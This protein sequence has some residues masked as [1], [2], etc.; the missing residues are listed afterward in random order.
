MDKIEDNPAIKEEKKEDGN[1]P[2]TDKELAYLGYL[3]Q[4]L[5]NA[6]L[7]REKPY[8]E[9][10]GMT[11]QSYYDSNIKLANSFMRP[12]LNKEDVRFHTGTTRQ[13]I[14]GLCT[15]VNQLNL[16]SE[17][18]VF[19]KKNIFYSKVARGLETV[20]HQ[21]KKNDKHEEKRS[22]REYELYVQGTAFNEV[23]WTDE[24]QL[25][26]D[27]DL[28]KNWDGKDFTVEW[29]G[30]LKKV[31]SG[32]RVNL[33]QGTRVFLGNIRE[34]FM[35]KQPYAFSYDKVTYEEAKQIYEKWE[36]WK[37]VKKDASRFEHELDQL[38]STY[39]D[40]TLLPVESGMVE[41]VKYQ[42]KWNN[43]FQIILNGVMMMPVGFPMPWKSGKYNITKDV[44]E[45]ITPTFA[46]GAS[47]CKKLKNSQMLENEFWQIA[48]LK[49][50]RSVY[51]AMANMTGR[52]LTQRVLA[53]GN[54]A[55]N[56]NAE[57]IK[58]IGGDFMAQGVTNSDI[59]MM[60]KM[61]ENL[62]QN[63]LSEISKGQAPNGNPT[64]TEIVQVQKEAMT[65]LGFAIFSASNMERHIDELILDS[66]IENWFEPDGD[67]VDE[68]RKVIK[69]KYRSA[70]SKTSIEGA[71]IGR[72]MVDLNPDLDESNYDVKAEYDL[73][74]KLSKEEG[75][76]VR[77]LVLNPLELKK[78][79]FIFYVEVFPKERES[80]DLQK[81]LFDTMAQRM[82]QFPNAN[83]EWL[84]EEFANVWNVPADKAFNKA[85]QQIGAMPPQGDSGSNVVQQQM[86]K[87]AGMKPQIP[88]INTLQN[89][90]A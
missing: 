9:F 78:K 19:D 87:R 64:A 72:R 65:L 36:R 43:E 10:D 60:D 89:A 76:P 22:L 71:G 77:R 90:P 27:S 57:G 61:R 21:V 30:R 88:S 83:M 34:F 23:M 5:H 2:Y 28:A 59:A 16:N 40:W 17:I 6:K 74:E 85:S 35:D 69:K 13:G 46:Y 63:S 42:D 53:P 32:V 80:S 62:N 70:S 54:F 55:H 84:E 12:K 79:D 33:I 52:V 45:Y 82:Q 86:Q 7:Q 15:K 81:V 37:Y 1:V 75:Q 68:A 56:I 20:M 38:G 58:V 3:R 48:I 67:E 18:K 14:L 4:R 26:K 8:D 51:P 11:Y 49:S 39:S 29:E 66:V 44:F 31:F 47:L 24:F 41:V 73:E 25:I 50:K